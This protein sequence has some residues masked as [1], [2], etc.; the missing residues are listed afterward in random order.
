M[1]QQPRVFIYARYSS[2]QQ[3]EKSADDQIAEC[4]VFAARMGWRIVGEAKDDAQTGQ[5]EQRQGYQ[6]VLAAVQSKACDILLAETMARLA[7]DAE[8]LA[9]LKK[10]IRFYRVGV[11]TINGGEADD[12]SFSISGLVSAIMLRD[13]ADQTRRGLSKAVEDGRSA[14]GL[15]YGYDIGRDARGDRIKGKLVVNE[16]EAAIVRRIFRE[17]AEG[18]SPLKIAAGLNAD[19]VPAPRSS[20]TGTVGHWKQN[21]INGNRERGTGILNNELYVGRRVWNRLTYCLNPMTDKKV[22]R[23]NPEWMWKVAEVP[24]LRIIDETLRASTR[25][26][27]GRLDKTRSAKVAHDPNGLSASQ[28]LRRRKFLLSGLLRCGIC[29]GNLTVAGS[30][31]AKRYYCANAK[32]KGKSVCKGMPGLPI[33]QAEEHVLGQ[34]REKLMNDTAFKAFKMSFE[35]QWNKD[36]E[37]STQILR[38]RDTAI[39]RLEQER[40]NIM[41]AVKLGIATGELLRELDETTKK[42]EQAK[43]NRDAA[44]PQE[45]PLPD[46]L[47]DQYRAYVGGLVQTLSDEGVVGRAS[48]LIHEMIDRVVVRFDESERTF[49][50]EIDGN[51]VKMLTASNP[52][53]GG[54]YAHSSSS[55]KL[56]AGTGFEPVTFR[57]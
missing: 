5:T 4:R 54:A 43:I 53:V 28:S 29:G 22:S 26:R 37:D 2:S 30:G 35:R 11:H 20:S 13:I 32:E 39:K 50:I 25:E 47:P 57:L 27:L 31:S 6:R 33:G 55:L 48:D 19:G 10:L 24:H 41:S 40:T 8:D 51:L 45:V 52:A 1:T 16:E 44:V 12:I 23:L 49:D 14:G 36:R 18:R 21:T 56:V 3:N 17:Y 38:V 7:R 9:A 42:L 15:S 46:D 34:L